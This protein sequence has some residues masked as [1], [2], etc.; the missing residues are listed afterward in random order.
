MAYEFYVTIEAASQGRLAGESTRELHKDK[1]TGIGFSYE[2]TSSRGAASGRASRKREHGAVTFTKEWGAAS[3]QL[4][5]AL[6]TN[7]VL[8]SA[9]FEFVRTN[10]VGVEHVFH[11]IALTDASVMSIHQYVAAQ[12]D[13]ELDNAELE[14]VALSFRGIEITNVDGTTAASDSEGGSW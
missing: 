3:P 11:T 13:A 9:L 5:Q 2:V 12:E 8:T 10:E 4:F 7:E 6:V 14:D 1:L